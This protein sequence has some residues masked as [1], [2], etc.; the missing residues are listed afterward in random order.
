MITGN[1]LSSLRKGRD[2]RRKTDL[3]SV[4]RALEL[5]YED[6]K[7]YPTSVTFNS[8]LTDPV[9]GKIYM[10]K[11]PTDPIDTNG[12]GYQSD[13]TYYRLFSC[14]E[15]NQDVATGVSQTGYAG[16][17]T[18]TGCGTCKYTITSTNITPYPAN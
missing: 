5:H 14:L 16:A 15:N 3:A 4:Q 6:K 13:G 12:Y 8:S 2:A 18:C 10:Q 11:L 17:P 9:S 7:A 1:F